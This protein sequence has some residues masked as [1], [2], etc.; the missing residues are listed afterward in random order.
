M[1][2]RILK[3]CDHDVSSG[4]TLAFK[5]GTED[6]RPKAI[7]DALIA[8]GFAEAIADTPKSPKEN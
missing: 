6:D 7:C 3:D 2:I 8:Q 4:R 1:K 5:A